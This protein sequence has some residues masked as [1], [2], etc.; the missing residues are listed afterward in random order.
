M[1]TVEELRVIAERLKIELGKLPSATE[2]ARQLEGNLSTN[3][4]RVTRML[5]EGVDYAKPLSK[6]EA[7][8]LGGAPI[9]KHVVRAGD[10]EG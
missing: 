3:F 1:P 8:K 6:L 2:I 5:T 10:Q 7:A 4:A 9:P